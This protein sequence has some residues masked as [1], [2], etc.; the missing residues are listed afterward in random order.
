MVKML[1]FLR[2][3]KPHLTTSAICDKLLLF[4]LLRKFLFTKIVCC[5]EFVI[6]SLIFLTRIFSSNISAL[7]KARDITCHFLSVLPC[8][9]DCNFK[10]IGNN[11]VR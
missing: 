3:F 1:Q 7:N 11:R 6:N 8:L 5:L 10:Q 2:F 9:K 4:V